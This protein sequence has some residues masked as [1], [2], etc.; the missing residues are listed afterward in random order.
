MKT[1]L[2]LICFLAL[3]TLALRAQDFV[4]INAPLPNLLFSVAAFGDIDNDGDL[5][6]Y[7]SGVDMDFNLK[8]GLYLYENG[9]YMYSTTANLPL[10]YLGSVA[11]GD[12][13]GDNL[14]DII[15]M[16]VNEEYEDFTE[17]YRN[18]GD[19]TFTSLNAGIIPAEQG[20]VQLIDIDGDG[21]LDV[22]ITGIGVNDRITKL[23]ENDGTGNFTEMT[24]VVLPGMNLG[25]IKWADYNNDGH[26]DFVLTGFNDSDGGT[27]DF[28]TKIHT[29]NGDG[30]FSVA[31][32]PLTRCWLGD[33]EWGDYNNDGF[34]DLVISGAGGDGAERFT[35]LYKNNGDGTFTDLD[36]GFPGVSHSSIEWADFNGDGQ[37]DLFIVGET[38]TPGEGSSI[39]KIYFNSGNDSFV[40]S[41]LDMFNIS[42][43]GD[44]DVGDFDGDGKIDLVITG[45]SQPYYSDASSTVYKNAIP[46]SVSELKKGFT[47]S[48]IPAKD[49]L[50]IK[51]SATIDRMTIHNMSGQVVLSQQLDDFS[52]IINTE[53]LPAGLY[54]ITIYTPTEVVTEKIIIE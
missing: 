18:N 41:G 33:A 5:D 52:H 43:Y 4:D 38:D 36:L 19:G 24:N 53:K 3:S 42:Y 11:W 8:G 14:L 20:E 16:G 22:A 51:S 21:D 1:N 48:P 28:Y 54:L 27:Q 44:A 49:F 37:L 31:D 25:R 23:Y 26:L 30:T 47:I 46:T 12:V 40:D 10:T 32:I 7:L 34:P 6:L 17:I 2:F 9:N 45:Y 13:D 50:T 39:S 35:I 29:N 15:L